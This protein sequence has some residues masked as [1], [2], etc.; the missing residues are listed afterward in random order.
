[1]ACRSITGS[2]S[3]PNITV[4]EILA[5]SNSALRHVLL[6]RFGLERFFSE[7]NAQVLD[8]DR[9]AGGERKLLR[10]PI[11]GDEDLVCVLVHCPS[12]GRRYILRVPPTMKTCREAIAWTAGFD[13]PGLYRPLIET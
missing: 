10:V 2:R 3:N 9:D 5:E 6:E 11:A 1:M 12:T 13:N 4:D 7:A 8:I